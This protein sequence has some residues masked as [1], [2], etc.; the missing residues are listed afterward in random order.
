MM[1]GI[2]VDDPLEDDELRLARQ[3]ADK[4][5]PNPVPNQPV[6]M[7]GAMMKMEVVRPARTVDVRVQV[8]PDTKPAPPAAKAPAKPTTATKKEV[9]K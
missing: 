6:M 4:N 8:K 7:K 1:G 2:M 9:P 5:D 3:E